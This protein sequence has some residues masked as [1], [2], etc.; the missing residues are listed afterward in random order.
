MPASGRPSVHSLGTKVSEG[1]SSPCQVLE[2]R[3]FAIVQSAVTISEYGR[4]S[5][6]TRSA[7]ESGCMGSSRIIRAG[8]AAG[9]RPTRG[10]E[11]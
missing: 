11:P 6:T 3:R 5:I 1:S 7:M 4:S 8:S 2:T 10:S 9:S